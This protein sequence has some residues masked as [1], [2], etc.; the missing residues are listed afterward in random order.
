[1]EVTWTG[2]RFEAHTR[3]EERTIPK[4]AGFRWDRDAKCWWTASAEL[5][6]AL[7]A[8]AD[9]S[10]RQLLDA[11]AEHAVESVAASRAAD[12]DIDIPV[13]D[14]LTLRP[15]Q[16]AGVA[17]ALG[18]QNTLIG[19]EMGLGKTL[20]ALGVINVDESIRKVLV[21]APLAV[22]INWQ[23]EAE[24]WLTRPMTIGFATA[25]E[26]PESDIV[27]I[28]PDV[29][30][31]RPEIH[32]QTWD[33]LVVDEA[34]LFKNDKAARTQALFGGRGRPAVQARRTLALTGTPIP[35]RPRELWPLVH[36]LAPAEF[37]SW[38]KFV[39]RYCG[40]YQDRFGWNTQGAT[41]LAELQEKLR[42][43]LMIRRRKAD[44]LTDLPAKERQVLVLDPADIS[45]GKA[46]V[47]KEAKEIA[48]LAKARAEAAIAVEL[49][50]AGGDET[51]YKEAVAALQGA[52]RTEFSAMS[53]LR[54]DTAVAKAPAVVE[55]VKEHLEGGVEKIGVWAHHHDVVDIVKAGLADFN[56]VVVTGETKAD[57]RQAAVDAFQADPQTR[58]FIGSITAAGVGIT[59]TAASHAVF[60][61]LDWVPGNV[62]QAE[63]RHHRIGQAESVLVQHV[64][65]DGSI[66]AKLAKTLLAKQAVADAALDAVHE[67]AARHEPVVAAD[68][69]VA[70]AQADPAV[71]AAE[72]P[73]TAATTRQR[74][75]E[76][77]ARLGP[78]DVDLVRRSL[79]TVAALDW[80]R[81]AELN[82]VG[83]SRL[84]GDLGHRLAEMDAWS[85]R[86][87]ALAA[88]L[89]NRYRGQLG[90][91]EAAARLQELAGKPPKKAKKAG[92]SEPQPEP[93][94]QPELAL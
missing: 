72:R 76:I 44:V 57:D 87:A 27:I 10:A 54:H 19:D 61:E 24:K 26:W 35:N 66:D 56:P 84:D 70:A 3:Y 71:A 46:A 52:A 31:R 38:Y 64:V 83:F 36:A 1:M 88:T 59:L 82:G 15:F 14:G 34:H 25:K 49:A 18:R 50:K 32:Q 60:A 75:D 42:A 92:G 47:R 94:P 63:D 51:A 48:A 4:A 65:L 17:Y 23:R 69:A 9:E 40:A 29:L 13:P 41:N 77:A 73:S 45:G 68:P 74:L 85:P 37:S 39:E 67:P 28:H 79:T 16:R 22:K 8:Y 91:D 33:L 58:V 43:T 78:D 80:D 30:A 21:V 89:A 90:D 93:E 12:A 62:S 81:A 6:A 11:A 20:Q 55:V 7:S 5:A 86:Q 53:R 2:R